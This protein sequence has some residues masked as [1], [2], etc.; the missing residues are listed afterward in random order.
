MKRILFIILFIISGLFISYAQSINFENDKIKK[1]TKLYIQ[2]DENKLK[3]I[4]NSK[5][6]LL[7]SLSSSQ[8]KNNNFKLEYKT[9]NNLSN[10][11]INNK[12]YLEFIIPEE[13]KNE[14]ENIKN[15]LLKLDNSL[16]IYNE[17]Q[18]RYSDFPISTTTPNDFLYSDKQIANLYFNN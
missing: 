2:G 3:N 16:I 5:N 14:K 17:P 4:L 11:I 10:K 9:L 15:K 6:T 13:Y 12:N 8:N 7:K 1:P 18:K